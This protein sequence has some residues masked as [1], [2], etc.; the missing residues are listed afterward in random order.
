MSSV[1]SPDGIVHL[2]V[3]G[4]RVVM[5]TDPSVDPTAG[6][7]V[8]A[9]V[10]SIY[11]RDDANSPLYCKT[12]A[13]QTAW[14]AVPI[15]AVSSGGGLTGDGSD[16]DVVL[17]AGTTTLVRDMFYNNLTV[18]A[19]STLQV[20][21][22]RVFV[23]GTLTLEGEITRTGL[24]GASVG[25][26][27]AA[28]GAGVS[29]VNRPLGG[30]SGGGAGN[31]GAGSAGT[32]TASTAPGYTASGGAGGAGTNA[33][34]AGGTATPVPAPGSGGL[35]MAVWAIMGRASGT[36]SQV[37]GGPGGG[38]GGGTFG[39]PGVGAIGGGGG[40]AG[41][42]LVVAA[43]I[44]TGAGSITANGGAG[45]AGH[46]DGA[47]AT[48][49]GGGGGGGGGIAVVYSGNNVFPT[50]TANG[51]AAGAGYS[52]GAAGNA[53]PAGQVMLFGP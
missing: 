47:G 11:L 45:G 44:I 36:S 16:G 9:P 38:G 2:G 15:S 50:V 27:P 21:G 18:P 13:A 17:G 53:G 6:A 1:Y 33:A 35:R 40:A 3:L 20:D 25:G 24:A 8:D 52:G 42:Y 14:A 39:G 31:S 19:G 29:S 30:T 34:G 22:Y 46:G 7:G 32:N 51:G 37:G 26:P 23:R 12:G 5:T 10:G 49:A 48:A 41:G 28:G 43:G 4:A